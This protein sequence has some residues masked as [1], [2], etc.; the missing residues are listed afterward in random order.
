MRYSATPP[1]LT[2]VHNRRRSRCKECGGSEVC[3]HNRQRS[4]CKE[5]GGKSICVHNRSFK[6]FGAAAH[7]A[8]VDVFQFYDGALGINQSLITRAKAARR[9]RRLGALAVEA[10]AIADAVDTQMAVEH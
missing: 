7:D 2:C 6:E 10:R 1:N 4:R 8:A 5:C 3:V 9:L